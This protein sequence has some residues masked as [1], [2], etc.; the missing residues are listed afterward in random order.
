[1]SYKKLRKRYKTMSPHVGRWLKWAKRKI[2]GCLLLALC[3]AVIGAGCVH[4]KLP[5]G[6]EYLRI[7]PQ[8]IGEVLI[9][10]PNGT[11]FLMDSQEAALPPVK[12]TTEGIFIGKEKP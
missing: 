4:V 1:M 6:T 10:F 5:D 9:E 8:K 11:Q 3:L 12:I 7:G 2:K